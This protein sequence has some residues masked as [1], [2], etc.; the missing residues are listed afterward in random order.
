M[1]KKDNRK[2][3][4]Y[5][6]L[7]SVLAQGSTDGARSI[8]KKYSGQDAKNL[9]D[10]EV[11]LANMY[12]NSPKKLDIEKDFA[13]IHPHKDFILKYNQPKPIVVEKVVEKE[14]IKSEVVLSTSNFDGHPPC[15]NPNCP[16]CNKFFNSDGNSNCTCN[17]SSS[18]CGCG[19]SSSFE[20]ETNILKMPNTQLMIVGVVGVVA[21]FG[22]FLY[23]NEKK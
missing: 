9:T 11:K 22:M 8:L 4:Q 2:N 10:L 7:L 23:L 18:A 5:A 16:R 12:S 6:T 3:V 15:G 20:G 19:G 13:D 14:P 21:I 17:K 1:S